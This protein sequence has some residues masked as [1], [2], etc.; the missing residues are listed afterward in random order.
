MTRWPIGD[1]A[2]EA[3]RPAAAAAPVAQNVPPATATPA[4][5]ARFKKVRRVI[6]LS[7]TGSPRLSA[8]RNTG[9]LGA[10]GAAM[11]STLVTHLRRSGEE[12]T[13]CRPRRRWTRSRIRTHLTVSGFETQRLVLAKS[14]GETVHRNRS[15]KVVHEA[16]TDRRL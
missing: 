1:S 3:R 9:T 14:C 6:E 11:G 13:S 16:P 2:G 10:K 5:P 12:L 4:A 15:Q 8:V 7:D